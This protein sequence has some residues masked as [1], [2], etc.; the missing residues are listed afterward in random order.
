[1]KY[2]K[3]RNIQN[4]QL[5]ARQSEQIRINQNIDPNIDTHSVGQ[6]KEKPAGIQ[7][8]KAH[9]SRKKRE[10]NPKIAILDYDLLMQ[11]FSTICD[12][13]EYKVKFGEDEGWGKA[14]A[15]VRVEA[16]NGDGDEDGDRHDDAIDVIDGC[17]GDDAVFFRDDQ[18]Q[19]H[20]GLHDSKFSHDRNYTHDQDSAHDRNYTHDQDSAHDQNYSHDQDSAHDQNYSHD[21]SLSHGAE[22]FPDP[23]PK[24]SSDAAF[25]A[26]LTFIDGPEPAMKRSR[27]LQKPFPLFEVCSPQVMAERRLRR[28]LHGMDSDAVKDTVD[29]AYNAGVS[30]RSEADAAGSSEP[31]DALRSGTVRF[32]GVDGFDCADVEAKKLFICGR[33]RSHEARVFRRCF[34]LT[35]CREGVALKYIADFLA[36]SH[37]TVRRIS[38]SVPAGSGTFGTSTSEPGTS[39]STKS[40]KQG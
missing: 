31:D 30:S 12:G 9:T 18:S 14:D 28:I 5:D 6:K 3:D 29:D 38:H 21:Q 27:M 4:I 7:S 37:E 40:T 36:V 13:S 32:D 26:Y 39:T 1:M 8:P 15:E 2:E 33:C 25:E 35:A 34:I 24:S 22:I 17:R 10:A 19:N 11:Y 23:K 16:E 20:M